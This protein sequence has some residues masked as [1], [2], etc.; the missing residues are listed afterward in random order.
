MQAT[1][2]A[3][4]YV[5]RWQ[6]LPLH[7]C[8]P[9]TRPARFAAQIWCYCHECMHTPVQVRSHASAPGGSAPQRAVVPRH[10]RMGSGSKPPLPYKS[11]EGPELT[12]PTSAF[13]SLALLAQAEQQ[14]VMSNLN[15]ARSSSVDDPDMGGAFGR[16][17]REL[18]SQFL[19]ETVSDLT[20]TKIDE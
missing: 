17:M 2:D 5:N 1:Q 14:G 7:C 13:A 6:P 20:Y 15:L 19:R 10:R 12:A 4:L 9:A 11:R 3:V 8:Y 18:K 16:S